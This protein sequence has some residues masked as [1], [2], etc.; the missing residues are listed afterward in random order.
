MIRGGGGGDC[1]MRQRG[2][3]IE[4]LL[5]EEIKKVSLKRT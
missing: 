1:E 2:D 4:V 3:T 5:L